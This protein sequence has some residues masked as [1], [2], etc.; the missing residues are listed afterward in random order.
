ML[1]D[2][3]LQVRP[4]YPVLSPWTMSEATKIFIFRLWARLI[5]RV[6]I[7][8]MLRITGSET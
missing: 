6:R 2:K 1:K 5:S 4:R 3:T 8:I 7:S